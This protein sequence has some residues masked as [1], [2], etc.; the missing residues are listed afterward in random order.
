MDWQL[1]RAE[2]DKQDYY[3]DLI[4]FPEHLVKALEQMKDFNF[5]FKPNNIIVCGMGGSAIP[6]YLLKNYCR[7]KLSLP[8]DVANGYDLPAW[9]NS[10]TLVFIISYSG[11]TEE[12]L[13]CLKQSLDRGCKPVLI[14]SGGLLER[15]AVKHSLSFIKAPNQFQP[16][17]ATP[18][19]FTYVLEVLRKSGLVNPDYDEAVSELKKL[20]LSIEQASNVKQLANQLVGKYVYVIVPE[21]LESIGRR[22]VSQDF[23]ENA[24]TLAKY[25]VIPETNH[26]ETTAWGE[27]QDLPL[28][29]IF[30]LDAD[31]S[32]SIKSRMSFS[33]SICRDKGLVVKVESYGKSLLSKM[34]T[35][36]HQGDLISY[37][38]CLL[39]HKDPLP[40]P[41]VEQLKLV[42]NE[43]TNTKRELIKSLNLK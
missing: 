7:L 29:S 36:I 43:Q 12:S 13:S 20:D 15:A 38:L 5:N 40:V 25:S 14:S 1:L 26:N 37:Y 39:R 2:Y 16:R 27:C 23:N 41:L 22:Y 17:A 4:K 19:L 35:L 32:N 21:H 42:L 31:A 33:E 18:Y 3:N 9:V 11:N 8:V 34:L 28:A 6:G 10:D 24:K 30:L